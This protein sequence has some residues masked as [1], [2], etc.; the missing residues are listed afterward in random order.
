MSHAILAEVTNAAI[1]DRALI[2]FGWQTHLEHS[3]HRHWIKRFYGK[4]PTSAGAV[5]SETQKLEQRI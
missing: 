2:R 1:S 5:F 4:Y 3:R